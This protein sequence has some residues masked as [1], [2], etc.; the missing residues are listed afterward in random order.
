MNPVISVEVLEVVDT[1]KSLLLR[2]MARILY[3]FNISNTFSYSGSA[4]FPCNPSASLISE[5]S[6]AIE[7][8]TQKANNNCVT[9][10]FSDSKK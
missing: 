1:K 6:I 7:N 2:L 8:P 9:I 3:F 5:A 10:I 4:S